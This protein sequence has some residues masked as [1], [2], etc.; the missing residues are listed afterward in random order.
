MSPSQ[1]LASTFGYI[2]PDDLATIIT[3][4]SKKAGVDYLIVDVR[5]D[6]FEGGHIPKCKNIPSDEFLVKVSQYVD[7]FRSVKKV[8]FHCALSQ[9][10]GPKCAS[11]YYAAL[12]NQEP[13]R[14]QEVLTLRG[15][16]TTWQ[17]K[18]K[19]RPELVQDYNEEFWEYN[20]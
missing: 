13:Q 1:P 7:E 11:R 16:F 4:P 10:R 5:G 6:D 9:V 17:A 18:Y 14:Q 2:E 8:V 19:K 20:Y 15:G 12:A 3:D